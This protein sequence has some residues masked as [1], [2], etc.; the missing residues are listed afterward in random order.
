MLVSLFL[1]YFILFYPINQTN[2]SFLKKKKNEKKEQFS[3][4]YTIMSLYLKPAGNVKAP[5]IEHSIQ[6]I[7]R[8]ASLIY[9]LPNTPF[10]EFFRTKKLSG[11]KTFLFLIIYFQLFCLLFFIYLCY[12]S[13]QLKN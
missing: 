6:Q 12:L 1:F 8:E 2:S 10:R 13:I 9:C 4:G 5:P 11:K 3:N 7:V